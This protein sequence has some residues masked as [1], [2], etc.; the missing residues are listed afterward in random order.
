MRRTPDLNKLNFIYAC[1][2]AA[3]F[4]IGEVLTYE[5]EEALNCKDV[6]P[7]FVGVSY[8]PNKNRKIQVQII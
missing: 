3:L 2:Y 1:R 8:N 5:S 7:K 4:Q 6:M